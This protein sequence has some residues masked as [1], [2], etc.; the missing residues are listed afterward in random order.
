MKI[1][2]VFTKLNQTYPTLT[3]KVSQ[4]FS[5]NQHLPLTTKVQVS[6]P[7]HGYSVSSLEA[8]IYRKKACLKCYAE[9]NPRIKSTYKGKWYKTRSIADVQEDIDSIYGIG[10]I[11]AISKGNLLNGVPSI[12][13]ECCD[14]G[15]FEVSAVLLLSNKQGCPV[16]GRIRKLSKIRNTREEFIESLPT[17]I[18]ETYDLTNLV[19]TAIKE[20]VTIKCKIHGEFTTTANG[21]KQGHGCSK[22]ASISRGTAY[23]K[24]G[25]KNLLLKLEEKFGSKLSWENLNYKGFKEEIVLTCSIHGDFITTP[26]YVFQSDRDTVCPY[27]TGSVICANDLDKEL[28]SK[29]RPLE[30]MRVESVANTRDE[31]KVKCLQC[32][33]TLYSLIQNLR[34]SDSIYCYHCID[35]HLL[36]G[37]SKRFSD[38]REHEVYTVEI[39][40]VNGLRVYKVG[41]SYDS[42]NRFRGIRFHSSIVATARLVF[43]KKYANAAEAFISEQRTLRTLKDFQYVGKPLIKN[44]GNTEILTIDPRSMIESINFE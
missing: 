36:V 34:D 5:E 42:E 43:T 28:S 18:K 29:Y 24:A 38:I 7:K 26:V 44:G 37:S 9:A 31:V 2:Q 16:C 21:L 20:N 35:P 25:L 10:K 6:C 4:L 40:T 32:G 17:S 14:H 27:C 15:P 39:T 3:F 41:F 11:K 23:K 8:C 1:N 13:C 19:Y 22:C 12:L 30:T 33:D